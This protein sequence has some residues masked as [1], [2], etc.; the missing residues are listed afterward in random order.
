MSK[1][2]KAPPTSDFLKLM[3]REY[4]E[5]LVVAIILALIIRLFIMSA[6]RVPTS[7]MA[8]TLKAGDYIFAMKLPYGVS[9][10]LTQKA[11]FGSPKPKRGDLAVFRYPQDVRTSFVKRVVGLPGDR[12]VIRGKQL[13]INGKAL[14]LKPV[15]NDSIADLVGRDYYEVYEELQ[16]SSRR[17][18][19][20]RIDQ[21]RNAFGP[22][23]VPP[24][25]VF[26]LGDNRDTSDDSRYWGL[27]PFE[28]LEA[29]VS[30]IWLSLDWSEKSSRFPRVRWERLF[31]TVD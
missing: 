13:F 14:P 6:Y 17:K 9:L 7:S 5:S 18:I 24:K 11:K 16:A 10:P 1:R 15:S 3:F 28:N 2:K 22:V 29:R 27:V 20:F 8:P 4:F 25:H 30:I 12:I 31:K 26:V 19:L 21:K 23:V